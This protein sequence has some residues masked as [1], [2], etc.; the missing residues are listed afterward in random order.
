MFEPVLAPKNKLAGRRCDEL[1]V[2]QLANFRHHSI[3]LT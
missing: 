1:V 2:D 3:G